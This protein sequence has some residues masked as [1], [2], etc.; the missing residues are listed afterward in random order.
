MNS[1]TADN[2]QKVAVAT[3]TFGEI[4]HSVDLLQETCCLGKPDERRG[5]NKASNYV[6][7]LMKKLEELQNKNELLCFVVDSIGLSQLPKFGTED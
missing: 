1:A 4:K 5:K 7:D 3:F 2:V 6:A